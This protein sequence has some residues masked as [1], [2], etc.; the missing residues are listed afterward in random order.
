MSDDG[1]KC[2]INSVHSCYVKLVAVNKG[3]ADLLR[4]KVINLFVSA[5][6][7]LMKDGSLDPR[8]HQ[9]ETPG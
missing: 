2:H 7:R 4:K 6:I 1:D 5:H 3:F 9:G 8:T